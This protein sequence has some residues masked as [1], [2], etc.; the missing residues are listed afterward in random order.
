MSI[1]WAGKI[2][3]QNRAKLYIS[4]VKGLT[5]ALSAGDGFACIAITDA[6]THAYL[7]VICWHYLHAKSKLI[8]LYGVENWEELRLKY[9][10]TSIADVLFKHCHDIF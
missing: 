7:E 10:P 9:W 2:W 8:R 5:E 1:N 3:L 4:T 6:F